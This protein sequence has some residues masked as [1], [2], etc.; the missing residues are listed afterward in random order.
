M[1]LS[2]LLG[3]TLL[4]L[5]ALSITGCPGEDSDNPDGGSGGI[6]GDIA[7][8]CKLNCP[9]KGIADGNASISGYGAIDGFFRS[10]VNFNTVA[11]GVS[12]DIDVELD[13]IQALFGISDAQAKAGL[14]A[15]IKAQLQARYMASVRVIATPA[16]CSV[17]ASIA[18]QASVDCQAEAKCS[19]TP[20]SAKFECN[21]TCTVEASATGS[22]EAN[23]DVRC[24]VT[25]PAVACQGQCN[26]TCSAKLD[27]AASCTGT[28]V[29]TCSGTCAGDTD[30][31]A[32]CNGQCMGMCQGTCD[33]VLEANAMCNGTCNGSCEFTPPDAKCSANAKVSCD[34]KASAKAECSGRCDGEF[35]PP[36]VMCDASASCQATA[37]AEAKFQAK[38]TP[39]TVDVRL[40]ST[41][42]AKVQLEA[43]F[44]L[45]ELKLRLPRLSAAVARAKFVNA[46]GNELVGAGKLAV[47]GTISAFTAGEVDALSLYRIG[48]CVPAQLDASGAAIQKASAELNAKVGEASGVSDAF[49][50]IM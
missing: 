30:S 37:K 42:D 10:V 11:K 38:C 29:G 32:G 6:L 21:G 43:Q 1:K 31:G 12:T 36:A 18:A 47:Q 7:D 4:A 19:G 25:G 15:A 28:C 41:G 5:G 44:L 45:T 33:V 3:V 22:C 40:V 8:Q 14:S 27:A 46:A 24:E 13:G 2:G 34:L 17:D 48:K 49:G 39:P 20:P 26:G 23:A 35:T 16:R 9:E 50:M